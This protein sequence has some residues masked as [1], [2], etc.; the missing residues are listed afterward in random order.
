MKRT[1]FYELCASLLVIALLAGFNAV[2]GKA[3]SSDAALELWQQKKAGL[4]INEHRH[5]GHGHAR[6]HHERRRHH[7]QHPQQQPAA[8]NAQPAM[9]PPAPAAT[10]L[11]PQNTPGTARPP[12][13]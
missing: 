1:L 6:R 12:V 7:D 11:V 13:Q 8:Q 4:V 5:R 10:P 3:A 2:T 9:V